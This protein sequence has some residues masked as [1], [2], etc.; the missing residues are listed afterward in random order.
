[1]FTFPWM[2]R[3]TAF[4]PVASISMS[5]R[6]SSCSTWPSSL[7]N[8]QPNRSQSRLTFSLATSEQCELYELNLHVERGSRT[9]SSILT[10]ML[11]DLKQCWFGCSENQP[12]SD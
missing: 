1:M 7:S 12:S 6:V 8:F 2:F 9:F 5:R 3:L 10:L 11:S 4:M